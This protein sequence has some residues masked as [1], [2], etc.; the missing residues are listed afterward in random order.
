MTCV[1]RDCNATHRTVTSMPNPFVRRPSTYLI[2]CLRVDGT[3]PSVSTRPSGG[4]R[5]PPVV[6]VAGRRTTQTAQR[7]GRA[8]SETITR[9]PKR[10]H[11]K[12]GRRIMGNGTSGTDQGDTD[13]PSTR[14]GTRR[15]YRHYGHLRSE[16]GWCCPTHREGTR[17]G[18]VS[19]E[20]PWKR[21][22]PPLVQSNS[23]CFA[24]HP[25]SG[26]ENVLYYTRCCPHRSCSN[27]PVRCSCRL[28]IVGYPVD[29]RRFREGFFVPTV[30]CNVHHH[31]RYRGTGDQCD[32]QAT[33]VVRRPRGQG[34]GNITPRINIFFSN[35]ISGLTV[36]PRIIVFVVY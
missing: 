3:E 35:H 21:K 28:V 29:C 12:L 31:R 10:R 26:D 11:S 27:A 5:T 16:G 30:P 7:N 34:L 32:Q 9:N 14:N 13:D 6:A 36:Q 17:G 22:Q 4:Q 18:V 19:R 20:L 1:Q 23:H 2:R 33:I 8:H 24:R 25:R 15:T